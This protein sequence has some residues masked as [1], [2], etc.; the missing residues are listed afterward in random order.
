MY[1]SEIAWASF[2]VLISIL[3]K[4]CISLHPYSGHGKPPMFGDYEAQRHWMEITYNLPTSMWYHNST[5]NNLNY[6]GLDYPPLTAYHSFICG[7][8]AHLINPKF[9]ELGRSHGYESEEHKLFMRYTVLAADV[10]IYIPAIIFYYIVSQKIYNHH[11]RKKT[12]NAGNSF[13]LKSAIVVSLIYPGLILID[14]GHFQYNCVSLGFLIFSIGFLFMEREVLCTIFFCMAL[15]YKQMELYH[16]FPFFLYLLSVCI[17]KPGESPIIGFLNVGK[18]GITVIAT[19]GILWFPFIFETR[20]F[21]QVLH[22]LFPVYR[23]VFEDKV[24]NFWCTLNVFNKLKDYCSNKMLRYCTFATLTA[25]LPSSTDLFLRPNIKKFVPAIINSSLS[26]FLFSY[27]VH[28]KSILLTAIPVLLY[29][30]QKPIPCFWFLFISNFSMFPLYVKDGLTVAY[31][32]LTV[33]Y[34]VAFLFC[35]ERWGIDLKSDNTFYMFYKE[36]MH[37]MTGAQSNKR[38][39]GDILGITYRHFLENRKLLKK[40]ALYVL[41]AISLLGSVILTCISLTFQPPKRYPDL[42]TVA[43]CIYSCAHFIGFLIYFH[44]VQLGIPQSFCKIKQH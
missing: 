30:P 13:A 17:P 31:V 19:F 37:V 33:F 44:V 21:L 12:K 7:Y 14:H 8:I 20:H 16:A 28:E 2:G 35:H 18:L 23:G 22:R 25:I 1:S 27:Q 38:S 43:I 42:F 36:V 26:F 40:L 29:L 39:Y 41:L 5:V 3:L 11:C 15:N 6:W 4:V 9:V 34:T 32:A 24:A 10:L